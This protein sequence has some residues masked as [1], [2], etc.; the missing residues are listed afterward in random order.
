[1]FQLHWI[2]QH[3][4]DLFIF[5]YEG[6]GL[7]TGIP[8]QEHTVRDGAA[9][10]A[11]LQQRNPKLPL[12]V[13]GQ[14]LGGAIAMRNLVDSKGKVPVSLAI[15]DSTFASYQLAA[16]KILAKGWLSWPFQWLAWLTISDEFASEGELGKLAP[17][18]LLVIHGDKD[19]VV[20]YD[21]GAAIFA[22][23]AQPKEMWTVAGGRHTD[24]F[25][26]P[27]YREKFLAYLEKALR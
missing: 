23:A 25:S 4:Y 13:Y 27:G 8:S 6:Y 1:M 12:V 16:R 14:S 21:C 7:S 20:S 9:A 19:Q 11:W 26:H 18:P 24:V 2:T 5:D 3:P 10:L 22:E 15:L 17:L